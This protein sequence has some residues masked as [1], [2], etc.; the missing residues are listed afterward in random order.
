MRT[1]GLALMILA[2]VPLAAQQIKFPPALEKLAAKAEKTV[3]V[4]LDAATIEL[5]GKFMSAEKAEEATAKKLVSGLKG[6][7]VRGF[8]FAKPGEYARAD[9]DSI[10]EQLK[11]PN[12]NCIISVRG[13]EEETEVCLY[14][15]GDAVSGFALLAAEPKQLTVVNIVGTISLEA[16]AALSKQ[17]GIAEQLAKGAKGLAETKKAV[18]PAKKDE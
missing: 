9:L 12:W 10:R 17:F 1:P 6:V 18:P 7:F 15:Q 16:L 4:N 3:N 11:D 5:A 14:R 2:A 13:K 8:E